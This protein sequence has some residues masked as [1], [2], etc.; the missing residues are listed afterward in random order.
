M[1]VAW[2]P[3]DAGAAA[4]GEGPSVAVAAELVRDSLLEQETRT[5]A[6]SSAARVRRRCTS[7]AYGE[8]RKVRGSYRRKRLRMR[9]ARLGAAG[10]YSM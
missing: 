9:S 10:V 1:P 5:V 7:R 6:E 8:R 2:D 3:E 4:V